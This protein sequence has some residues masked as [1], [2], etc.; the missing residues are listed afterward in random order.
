MI[1]R[2]LLL[3]GLLVLSHP[4]SAA[5]SNA[6]KT[7]FSQQCAL[8]HSAEPG[9][10]GGAQGPQLYE[11]RLLCYIRKAYLQELENDQ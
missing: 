8:C 6:G 7:F 2:N 11:G 5:D 1:N 9:D 10:N 4:L 3:A